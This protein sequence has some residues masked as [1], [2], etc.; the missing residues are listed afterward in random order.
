MMHTFCIAHKQLTY[1]ALGL[2]FSKRQ[3]AFTSSTT[4][5]SHT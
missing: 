2:G 1:A 5:K 3:R 4:L